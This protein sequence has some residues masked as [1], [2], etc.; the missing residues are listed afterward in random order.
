MATC[1]SRWA[2]CGAWGHADVAEFVAT[3]DRERRAGGRGFVGHLAA[4]GALRAG[5]SPERAVDAVWALLAPDLVT[6]LVE[7]CG[8]PDADV[9]RWLAEQLGTALLGAG[10]EGGRSG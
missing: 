1:G 10:P 9:E 5:L 7:E 8:W 6:R 4:A 3:T 2:S